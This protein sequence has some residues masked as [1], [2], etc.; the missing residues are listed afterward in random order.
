MASSQMLVASSMVLTRL[1]VPMVPGHF[2]VF[3][4]AENPLTASLS[5]PLKSLERKLPV[6]ACRKQMFFA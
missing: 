5:N 2:F 3:A 4:Y 6:E 1:G